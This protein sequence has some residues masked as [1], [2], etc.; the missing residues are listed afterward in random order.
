MDFYF[1]EA[2]NARQES[3]AAQV[4]MEWI[5]GF[6]KTYTGLK[7]IGFE[8]LKIHEYF[9]RFELLPGERLD[10]FLKNKRPDI[11][12]KF[13]RIISNCSYIPQESKLYNNSNTSVS[14]NEPVVARGLGAAFLD[15]SIA[16]GFLT[17]S[18][19][20]NPEIE[21]QREYIDDS[22]EDD[23]S[24]ENVL[25]KHAARP[26]HTITHKPFAIEK[27]KRLPLTEKEFD[28]L[29]KKVFLPR[30][31]VSNKV[32]EVDTF[33]HRVKSLETN[34]KVARYREVGKDVAEI[35][36]YR[37]NRIISNINSSNE[38]IRDIFSIEIRPSNHLFLSID[39]R[40]GVFETYDSSGNHLGEIK[41][42]GS[43]H[44]GP[45]PSHNI[46]LTN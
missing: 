15:N 1:N 45:K 39:V 3:V 41:F 46:R 24:I 2:S 9:G 28:M 21:I 25:V 19:W 29:K 43:Y 34:E 27:L 42:S 31:G 8:N 37:K 13:R 38:R 17:D 33:W 18:F 22:N 5:E 23:T 10:S 16:I 26:Q 32:L 7:N 35:N 44:S 36:G 30:A 6:V 11:I 40:H 12:R 4:S 20:D 14:G